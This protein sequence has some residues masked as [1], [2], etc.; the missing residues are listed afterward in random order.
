[1][2]ILEPAMSETCSGTFV[3]AMKEAME[4]AI[5]RGVPREAAFDF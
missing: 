2:A 5:S 4:E 1:M 3:V